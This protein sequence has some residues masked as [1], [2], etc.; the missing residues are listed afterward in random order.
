MWKKRQTRWGLPPRGTSKPGGEAA[1]NAPIILK[2][3]TW[4]VCV[5]PQRQIGH[6][7]MLKGESLFLRGDNGDESELYKMSLFLILK[8]LAQLY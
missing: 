6:S 3:C 1:C 8:R 7:G 4:Y 5:K 2:C